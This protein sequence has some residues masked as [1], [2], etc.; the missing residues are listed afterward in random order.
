MSSKQV[1]FLSSIDWDA[2]WQRHQA[3]ASSFA[4]AGW[5]V[6]FVENTGFRNFRLSDL[7]RIS[8][9][10]FNILVGGRSEARIHPVPKGVRLIPPLVLPPTHPVFRALNRYWCLP[11]LARSLRHRGLKESPL[12]F[13]YIPSQTT[14]DLLALMQPRL[15]VYDVVDHYPRHPKPPSD[16]SRTE[17]ELIRSADILFTTS[18]LLQELHQGRHP[19]VLQVH[20]GVSEEFFLPAPAPPKSHR[21]FCYFGSL[22]EGLDYA[23]VNALALAGYE[24]WLIG[25]EKDP[26]P[27][28]HP[29]VHREGMLSTAELARRLGGFDAL[30]LPYEDTEWNR[31]IT[32]AKIYECLATGLPVLASEMPGLVGVN[33]LLYTAHGP[34]GFVQAARSLDREESPERVRA[35]LAEA[36][37]HSASAQ[38][39]K[40][41]G[42]LAQ[43]PREAAAGARA[44]AS[45]PIP[46]SLGAILKGLTWITVFFTL[47]KAATLLTQMA[48][49]RFLGP[50][51]YGTASL[52]LAV[53]SLLQI[54][55]MLGFPLALAHFAPTQTT[56][57]GRQRLI[58]TTLTVFAAWA[59]LALGMLL[60]AEPWLEAWSGLNR[61]QWRYALILAFLTAFHLTAAACL[62]GLT[63]FKRRGGAEALYGL[64]SAVLLALLAL[65]GEK[66]YS[67]IILAL[68]GGLSIGAFYSLWS[69]RSYLRLILDRKLLTGVLP[70]ALLGTLN[71]VATSLLQAPGRICLHRFDSPQAVGLYSA[72][73]TAT[74]Q[75]ALAFMTM[76]WTVLIPLTSRPDGQRDAWR[77]LKRLAPTLIL[78]GFLLFTTGGATAALILGRSYAAHPAWFALFGAA[79]SFIFAHGLFAALFAARGLQGLAV[80]TL[81]ALVAGAANV[82]LNIALAPRWGVGGSATALALSYALGLAWLFSRRPTEEGG[83]PSSAT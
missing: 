60:A 61:T 22:R 38:F 79:G 40:I 82:G 70:Y 74:A 4:Q 26:P 34:D 50:A 83:T 9:R 56:N 32:P 59:V 48:A 21:R 44:R 76:A 69:L 29:G 47:S 36:R 25:P 62:Q 17:E 58:S 51:E 77:Q 49:A 27:K 71:I 43:I 2:A 16:L 31:G 28:L 52:I 33:G 14:L 75:V 24:V 10:L 18:P 7:G 30:L 66:G 64:S 73:F 11:R 42:A 80:S 57:A 19:R 65:R 8:R 3:L 55:P 63:W 12:I 78:G 37:K 15:T 35:R 5:Q 6:F 45:V 39:A 13:C 67:A 20:H 23:A 1:V 53:N 81:G 68:C 46:K 41:L 72:Y 54:L